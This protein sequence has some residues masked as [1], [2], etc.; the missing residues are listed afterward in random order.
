M[1]DAS[2]HL[3][4]VF[5]RPRK[6]ARIVCLDLNMA[7]DKKG[8]NP[9]RKWKYTLSFQTKNS[10]LFS[11]KICLGNSSKACRLQQ[12][13]SV[14]TLQKNKNLEYQRFALMLWK[15]VPG[16]IIQESSV[17]SEGY[18]YKIRCCALLYIC[19]KKIKMSLP[20]KARKY[21]NMLPVLS[22]I[23]WQFSRFQKWRWH[24]ETC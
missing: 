21:F 19:F 11:W 3:V 17:L 9:K 8:S 1:I 13:N 20:E 10:S 16:H 2:G 23:F 5:L 18:L 6:G 14:C 12:A 15:V 4:V 22:E 7:D 24:I